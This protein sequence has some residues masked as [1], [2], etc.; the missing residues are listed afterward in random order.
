[1]ELLKKVSTYFWGWQEKKP[2][3]LGVR[4]VCISDTHG[5]HRDVKVPDG[6]ILI[7]AGDFTHFGKKRDLDN[8]NDWLGTLPHKVRIVVNGNHEKNA[9][10]K[11]TVATALSN[12]IFIKDS[13]VEIK[14]KP[15]FKKTEGEEQKQIES[16]KS[17]PERD[18]TEQSEPWGDPSESAKP[19]N[20][21]PAATDGN[22]NGRAER[23]GV[24]ST[25]AGEGIESIK[26]KIYGTDFFWP[27]PS[28][29]PYYGE[30]PQ[31]VDIVIS[32]GPAKGYV[33]GGCGCPSLAKHIK[34]VRPRLL[35]G[36]HVHSAHGVTD[37][38]Y[39]TYVNAAICKEGYSA[40]WEAVVVDI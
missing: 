21:D 32:H 17:R 34:R 19:S 26:V 10:W 13:L 31:G 39:T 38:G 14:I 16:P 30:I 5:R 9:E 40:G 22:E 37:D 27:C 29:N 35:I 7:H 2:E 25:G 28:G 15:N 11:A 6:D 20:F 3:A 4:I 36:G 24:V 1:M 33:D 12:A 18:E 23:K 8:F